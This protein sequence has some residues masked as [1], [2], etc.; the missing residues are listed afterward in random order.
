[1]CIN[2]LLMRTAHVGYATL[3]CGDLLGKLPE[4][5]SDY[6][7]AKNHTQIAIPMYESTSTAQTYC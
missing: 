5:L 1:M 3:A 2:V 4:K 6:A 7:W